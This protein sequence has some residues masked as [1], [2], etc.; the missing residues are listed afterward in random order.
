MTFIADHLSAMSVQEYEDWLNAMEEEVK[1]N[2]DTH[3]SFLHGI[4]AR[5]HH[6]VTRGA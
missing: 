6:G 3:R 2:N 5:L 4:T 1:L